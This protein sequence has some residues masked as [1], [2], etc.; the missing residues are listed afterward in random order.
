MVKAIKFLIPP[1]AILVLF[2]LNRLLTPLGWLVD[3]PLAAVIFLNLNRLPGRWSAFI[4]AGI[5]LDLAFGS[6][7][8]FLLVLLLVCGTL[9]LLTAELSLSH[10]LA[11]IF[12]I[13]GSVGGYWLLLFL[14]SRLFGWIAQEPA[15]ALLLKMSVWQATVYILLNTLIIVVAGQFFYQSKKGKYVEIS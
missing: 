1:L 13:L 14:I 3:L 2:L 10:Q 6:P 9:H 8:V 15:Y 12:L 11:R 4:T 5:L 7:G